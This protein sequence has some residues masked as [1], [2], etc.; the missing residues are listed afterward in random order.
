MGYIADCDEY[1][2][3]DYPF[4][5]IWKE[6]GFKLGILR[7]QNSLMITGAAKRITLKDTKE[8]YHR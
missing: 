2:F 1:N 5:S 6:K 8:V 7:D 3:W 4:F